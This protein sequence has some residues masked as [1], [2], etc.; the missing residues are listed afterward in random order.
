MFLCTSLYIYIF[1]CVY[2]YALC[3]HGY[4][5]VYIYLCKCKCIEWSTCFIYQFPCIL[6]NK[7]YSPVI[8]PTDVNR[9]KSSFTF[10]LQSC[11]HSALFYNTLCLRS[12]GLR[13]TKQSLHFM[14]LKPSIRID[15]N[16]RS[17][18]P[19]TMKLHPPTNTEKPINHRWQ[20]T[21]PTIY[22]WP[23]LLLYRKVARLTTSAV[24]MS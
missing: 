18:W 1:V 24:T 13:R 22:V 19:A 4:D 10:C 11:R 20:V 8:S 17:Y 5:Y 21:T 12:R 23:L 9:N 3:M 16:F 15:G 14:P 2:G 7:K 6:C